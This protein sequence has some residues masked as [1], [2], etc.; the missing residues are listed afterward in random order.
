MARSRLSF[1]PPP[2]GEQDG[3]VRV[4]GAVEPVRNVT[5]FSFFGSHQWLGAAASRLK[6]LPSRNVENYKTVL[7]ASGWGQF[8]HSLPKVGALTSYT[9]HKPQEL[10][11]PGKHYTEQLLWTVKNM[12]QD[13]L[14]E[15]TRRARSERVPNTTRLCPQDVTIP[16]H[17]YITNQKGD[18]S[19]HVQS[20]HC[21]F[22]MSA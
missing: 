2:D 22:I 8:R 5:V 3:H 7:G 19:F 9:R 6:L 20:F 15:G 11:H 12:T 4:R 21:G 16:A 10:T 1:H 17:Y 18:P 13:Q 14:K